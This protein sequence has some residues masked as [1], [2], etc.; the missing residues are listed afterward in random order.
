MSEGQITIAASI[1]GG[2]KVTEV[3]HVFK[4]KTQEKNT[5]QDANEHIR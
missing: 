2:F 4:R 3:S 1:I 5:T